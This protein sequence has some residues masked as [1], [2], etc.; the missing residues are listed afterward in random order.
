MADEGRNNKL[1]E[2]VLRGKKNKRR[3]G[4]KKKYSVVNASRHVHFKKKIQGSVTIVLQGTMSL[5][6]NSKNVIIRNFIF[7]GYTTQYYNIKIG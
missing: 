3:K 2:K 4:R 5:F 1:E 6:Y 7:F